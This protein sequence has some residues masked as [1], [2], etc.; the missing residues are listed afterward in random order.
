MRT[1]Q[2]AEANRVLGLVV[3][4]AVLGVLVPLLVASVMRLGQSQ[5]VVVSHASA[6]RSVSDLDAL[7]AADGTDE[8]RSLYLMASRGQREARPQ[9]GGGEPA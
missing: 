3:A 9:L 2:K 8:V 5:Q 6:H 4:I 1:S 7:Y